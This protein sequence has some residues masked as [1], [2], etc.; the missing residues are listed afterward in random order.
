MTKYGCIG[1]RLPHSFSKEIHEKIGEYNYELIELTPAELQKF[2]EKADFSGINVTIPYKQ[3]VI[4]YLYEISPA[5]EKIGAVNTVVNRGGKLYG[6]NTDFG[7]M[8]AL[9]KKNKIE[10][11]GKKALILGTGGTAK[12]ASAVLQSLGVKSFKKVSRHP[13]DGEISYDEVYQNYADTEL[14]VNT[15]P[16]GMF[17][18]TDNAPIEVENFPNLRSLVDVIYNPLKTRL[19]RNAEKFGVTAVGG[20]YMLVA[21]AVLAAEIFTEKSFGEDVIDSIYNDILKLKL[22]L[23]LIGMPGSGK[24]TVGEILAHRMSRKFLDTDR[25]IIEKIGMPIAEYFEK[26]GEAAFRKIETEVIKEASKIGGRVIATG[27]GAVLNPQNIDELKSN[28]R[29]YF[30]DRPLERLVPTADRPLANSA[31][32]IKKRYEERYSKYLDAADET[33]KMSESADDNADFIMREWNK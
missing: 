1:E 18:K 23:T 24:T 20:L 14:I 22:N 26:F 5:A 33:I 2:M 21:Q 17:P 31:E 13:S 30:L 16:V 25:L 10:A 29:I 12:T 28:G 6:Y 9:I 3:A 19:V 27:G 32:V 8:K 15:T 11:A 4:P 7:G